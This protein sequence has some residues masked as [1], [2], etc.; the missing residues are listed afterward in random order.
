M[1]GYSLKYKFLSSSYIGRP[2]FGMGA[3]VEYP[4]HPSPSPRHPG[5]MQLGKTTQNWL[6]GVAGYYGEGPVILPIPFYEGMST[7]NKP[8]CDG[9]LQADTAGLI[10][11]RRI[12]LC[13]NSIYTKSKLGKNI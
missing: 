9:H 10:K 2:A 5:H 8:S 11:M 3:Q 7:V 4:S 12:E 6:K 13:S 1:R